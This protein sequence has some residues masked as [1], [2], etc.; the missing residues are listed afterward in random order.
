MQH[1]DVIIAGGGPVGAALGIELGLHQ[2]N[3]LLL[4]KY[5]TPLLSPRAQSLNARSMEFFIRWKLAEELKAKQLLPPDYPIQGVWCSGLNG[6]TYA[7]SSSNSKLNDEISPERGSRI[8]LWL[9]EEVL[10]QRLNDFPCVTFL[11]QHAVMDVSLDKE[12]V[13][14]D[15]QNHLNER[16]QFSAPYVVACDGANSIVRKKVGID[17]EALAKPARVINIIFESLELAKHITVEKG[18]LYYLLESERPGALGAIDLARGLWYAQIRDD[19]IA[20]SI[21]EMNINSLIEELTGIVFAKKIIQA[22]FWNMH[23]QLANSFSK[24]NRVFLMGDS[25]HAFVPTGG[26]GLN[27][28][29]GDV[30]NFGWK[31]A[32]VI[33]QKAKPELLKTYEQERRPVCLNNLKAAQKNADDMMILRKEHDPL[34]DPEGFAK[35]NAILAKQHAHSLGATMGYAYFDSPLTLLQK[36]QST[37]PMEN[38]IYQPTVAPGYFLP[39]VSLPHHSSIYKILSA[40]AWTLIVSGEEDLKLIEAWQEKF[41]QHHMRLDILNL[42]KNTYAIQYILIRPDWQIAYAEKDLR[43]D[44]V[45]DCFK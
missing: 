5:A 20:Q 23:I 9:T 2:I 41:N 38:S 26:F 45:F 29:L 39:H 11:K 44:Y 4:E 30:V 35:G 16:I 6:K 10:R 40:T 21:E 3:T 12:T 32:A 33:Q 36:D 14:I 43:R 19:G 7:V 37:V 13:M 27:T 15:A 31:L 1:Y 24:N 42:P 28:G 25:A 18:I 17:F 34:K 8:P 22:H